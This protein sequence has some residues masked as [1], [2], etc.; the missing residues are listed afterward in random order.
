M[1]SLQDQGETLRPKHVLSPRNSPT[2][3]RKR[4]RMG[5]THGTEYP[6]YFVVSFLQGT[7]CE[8]GTSDSSATLQRA[9]H[10][11]A[12]RPKGCLCFFLEVPT[13]D[14]DLQFVFPRS[15]DRPSKQP[16]GRLVGEEA[17]SARGAA[18]AAKGSRG[19]LRAFACLRRCRESHR[20]LSGE[21][22]TIP[23]L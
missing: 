11:T 15:S 22:S 10:R 8:A 12:F 4:L 9:S 23:E 2:L 20:S 7:K 19:G 3:I 18:G 14:A 1:P 17:A 13:S 16:A 5:Q 6:A 21:A